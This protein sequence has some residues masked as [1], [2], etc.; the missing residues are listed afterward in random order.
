VIA[1]VAWT[2]AAAAAPGA[3]SAAARSRRRRPSARRS[4]S[5]RAGT[6]GGAPA[7][8]RPRRC[9]PGRSRRSASP[10]GNVDGLGR[11][12]LVLQR[13]GPS[14]TVHRLHRGAQLLDAR[15]GCLAG[16]SGG[17][18]STGTVLEAG[19]SRWTH[20]RRARARRAMRR[21]GFARKLR[22]RERRVGC[23][24]ILEGTEPRRVTRPSRMR[25][26]RGGPSGRRAPRAGAAVRP[27]PP[28]AHRGG[29]VRRHPR[30]AASRKELE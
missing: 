27:T 24:G 11:P 15:R 2:P 7:R 9:R 13:D 25:P 8:A 10:R 30:A 5:R 16:R 22:A 1:T 3:A 26:D 21:C 18:T 14:G 29:G 19:P 12:A 6:R 28:R 17:F 23:R 4:P 20:R